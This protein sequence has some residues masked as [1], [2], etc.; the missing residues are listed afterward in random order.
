MININ[1]FNC[2]LETKV[3]RHT[4]VANNNDTYETFL[5]KHLN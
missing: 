2:I 5:T 3:K 4:L 1:L